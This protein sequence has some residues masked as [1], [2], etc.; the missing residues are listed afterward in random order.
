MKKLFFILSLLFPIMGL[1][2]CAPTQKG[3]NQEKEDRRS[4]MQISAE[5]HIHG[6]LQDLYDGDNIKLESY[7]EPLLVYSGQSDSLMIYMV[8][9]VILA[10]KSELKVPIEFYYAVVTSYE[11]E[12]VSVNPLLGNKKSLLETIEELY[13]K[14]PKSDQNEKNKDDIS[15][16]AILAATLSDKTTTRIF[17]NTNN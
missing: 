16:M 14:L 9:A 6:I 5:N 4:Q 15:K 10:A 12:M 7:S 2:G 13:A 11:G 3:D 17:N 8:N 1:S